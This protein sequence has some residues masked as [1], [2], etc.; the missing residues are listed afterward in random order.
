MC[1]LGDGHRVYY[2][3]VITSVITDEV[4]DLLTANDHENGVVTTSE[5]GAVSFIIFHY[6]HTLAYLTILHE[7]KYQ[8]P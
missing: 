4:F 1:C 3:S 2:I 6:F 8:N 7:Q 5:G